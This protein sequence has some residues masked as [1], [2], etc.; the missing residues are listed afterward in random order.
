MTRPWWNTAPPHHVHFA[1]FLYEIELEY[2]FT[3]YLC[4]GLR[5]MDMHVEVRSTSNM[6]NCSLAFYFFFPDKVSH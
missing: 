2:V 4:K 1:I 5:H 6:L 3:S